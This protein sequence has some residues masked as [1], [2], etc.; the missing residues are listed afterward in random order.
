MNDERASDRV[1][2]V[3]ALLAGHLERHAAGDALALEALAAELQDPE[4][5]T[6]DLQAAAWVLQSLEHV[7]WGGVP[8][9]TDLLAPGACGP[10]VERVPSSEERESLGPEAWGYLLDLRRQGALDAAQFERVVDLLAG[11]DTRP[12]SLAMAREAAAS[13]ILH[14]DPET[15]ET[16]G[17]LGVAH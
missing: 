11:S 2:R 5:T 17:D 13:V 6:D 15:S 7:A 1:R 14:L 4:L 10:P 9:A 12:V 8:A 3:L 16:Y